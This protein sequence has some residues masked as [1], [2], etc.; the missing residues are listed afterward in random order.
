MGG[1]PVARRER[2]RE[3][4]PGHRPASRVSM[5]MLPVLSPPLALT[6][7]RPGTSLGS[8]NQT[9]LYAPTEHWAQELT[10]P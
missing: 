4:P 2:P 6:T 10:S 7:P 1:V 5:A 8:G 9:C 3:Q